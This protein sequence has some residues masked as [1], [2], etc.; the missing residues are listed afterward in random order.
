MQSVCLKFYV[1]FVLEVFVLVGLF[2]SDY[3]IF[4]KVYLVAQI[5]LC[6]TRIF[7]LDFYGRINKAVIQAK[8][9]DRRE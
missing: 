3:A 7:S 9:S 2:F 8:G 4:L 5:I 6:G 1:V